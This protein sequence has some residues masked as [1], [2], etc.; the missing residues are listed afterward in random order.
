MDTTPIPDSA[1][2]GFGCLLNIPANCPNC[3]T[4]NASDKP[5]CEQYIQ[6]YITQGCNPNN[7]C[8]TNPSGVCGVNTIGGGYAPEM[9]AV[10]TY[11]CACP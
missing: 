8:G 2:D 10:A 9:A 3:M 11:D 5:I 4:Q 7:A 1:P 6:C